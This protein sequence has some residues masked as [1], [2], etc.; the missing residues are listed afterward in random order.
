ML[1]QSD[2]SSVLENTNLGISR[3]MPAYS[4]SVAVLVGIES[5]VGQ[6]SAISSWVTRPSRKALIAPSSWLKC[7][8]SSSST[9]CQSSS[10]FGPSMK[11]ST[12]TD[13]IQMIFLIAV[14]SG[15]EAT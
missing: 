5:A 2:R 3:Q 10:R 4:T 15:L 13:I 9:M 12:E 8:C 14:H 1:F 6:N 7:R 11:P